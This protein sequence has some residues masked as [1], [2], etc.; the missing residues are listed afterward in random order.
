MSL[1]FWVKLLKRF[2]KNHI[3]IAI[4]NEVVRKR[5]PLTS[6]ITIPQKNYEKGI[7]HKEEV[8]AES[9]LLKLVIGRYKR[10]HHNNADNEINVVYPRKGIKL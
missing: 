5:S 8:A 10:K 1:T 7:K 9:L 3:P 4:V 2:S 6:W